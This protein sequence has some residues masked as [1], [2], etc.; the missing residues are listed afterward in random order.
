MRVPRLGVITEWLLA[1]V[2]RGAKGRLSESACVSMSVDS[3]EQISVETSRTVLGPCLPF[4]WEV[5]GLP[6]PPPSTT[7]FHT[8]P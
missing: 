6:R 8:H 1:L 5:A 7:A 3:K 2:F 4:L